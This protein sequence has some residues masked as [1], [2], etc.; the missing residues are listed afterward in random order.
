MS[1]MLD[2]LEF[3]PV[4]DPGLPEHQYRPTDVDPLLE[5][6]AERQIAAMFAMAALLSL[7]FCVA[8]F[9]IDK[10][11]RFL[12]WSAMNFALGSTLGGAMLL[13]GSGIIKWA[14]QLMGDH[15]V[16]INPAT[17]PADTS[18]APW[19]RMCVITR[20]LGSPTAMR[21]AQS[22]RRRVAKCVITP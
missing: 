14:K 13:I 17:V 11:A 2:K 22:R 10:D 4:A 6:R 1:D 16:A 7:G 15:G 21:I 9:A 20:E 18:I 19:P 5:K 12:G 3:D 8:Y